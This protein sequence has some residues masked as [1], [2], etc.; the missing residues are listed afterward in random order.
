[1]IYISTMIKPLFNRKI[2]VSDQLLFRLDVYKIVSNEEKVDCT[3]Y[4][5]SVTFPCQTNKRFTA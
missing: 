3:V 2:L 4:Q 1:M 5:M